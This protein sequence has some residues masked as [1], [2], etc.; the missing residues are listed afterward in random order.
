[1]RT[2]VL[3]PRYT[4]DSNAMWR[5]ATERGW[6]VVRVRSYR[7]D[8]IDAAVAKKGPVLYGETLLA[9]ALAEPLGL[10]VVEPSG[11]WL[12]SLPE[13]YRKREVKL[14]TLGKARAIRHSL[15]AKPVD[16]KIFKSRVYEEGAM[17]DP[18]LELDDSEAVHVSDVVTF[19]LEVRLFVANRR[20]HT[21]SAYLRGGTIAKNEAGEWPLSDV[22]AKE[23]MRFANKLLGDE[24]VDLPEALVIDV[25]RTDDRG[26]IVVEANPCWAS[27]LCGC[28]P[29]AALDVC[30]VASKPQ[31]EATRWSRQPKG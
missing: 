9:D 2:L 19:D 10:V 3:S 23:A 24:N 20:V 1:M 8:A 30:A 14:T 28:D 26:W 13:A 18:D 4:D 5:A 16:E 7:Q 6:D 29:R 15:F 22:E 27:G 25:G 31:G 21:Y 11:T 17:I 12:P